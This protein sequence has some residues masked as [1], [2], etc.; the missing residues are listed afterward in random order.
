MAAF[1]EF[2]HVEHSSALSLEQLA[3]KLCCVN[4]VRTRAY[5]IGWRAARYLS[6]PANSIATVL[7]PAGLDKSAGLITGVFA[8]DPTAAR[9][10][11]DPGFKEYA[12]FMAKYMSPAEFI[13]FGAVTAFGVAAMLIPV[14]KQCGD[15]LSRENIMRQAANLKNLDL[16]MLLPGI[17]VNTSPD[18][19][20]PIRQ[21]Q[22]ASFNGESWEQ[23]GDVLSG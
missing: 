2:V 17:K 3:G 6:N 9:W 5:D 10:K 22:L 7:K 20:Y 11:D 18:N 16:P 12:A 19:Y 8:K 23:F 1:E 4:A 15:D 14:L 13:D 21:M